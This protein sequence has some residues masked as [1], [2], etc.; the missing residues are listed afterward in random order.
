MSSTRN[1]VIVNVKMLR[2]TL[3]NRLDFHFTKQKPPW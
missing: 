2:N 1:E 3:K